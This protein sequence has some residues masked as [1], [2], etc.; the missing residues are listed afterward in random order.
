MLYQPTLHLPP[1]SRLPLL[2]CCLMLPFAL[3]SLLRLA[4][5]HH[6]M[7]ATLAVTWVLPALQTPPPFIV[8][9]VMPTAAPPMV[10]SHPRLTLTTHV[11]SA[12]M[13][14][15]LPVALVLSHHLL[16]SVAIRCHTKP[17]VIGFTFHAVIAST[18]P[19]SPRQ[20]VATLLMTLAHH[21]LPLRA[22][23]A[24][25]LRLAFPPS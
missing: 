17:C 13:L 4:C 16:T 20:H 2:T 1:P 15:P 3:A 10:Q 6:L 9:F 7:V 21:T 14:T 22:L 18:V 24:P 23:S 5:H 25:S 8:S 11:P 19:A 12:W